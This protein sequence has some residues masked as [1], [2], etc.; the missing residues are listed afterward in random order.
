[1]FAVYNSY[2]QKEMNFQLD[3]KNGGKKMTLDLVFRLAIGVAGITGCCLYFGRK[4][5]WLRKCHLIMGSCAF[6]LCAVTYFV[7]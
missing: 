7:K 6:V 5:E 2:C 3:V 1:M 4:A